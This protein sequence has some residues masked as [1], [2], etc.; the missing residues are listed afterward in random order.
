MKKSQTNLKFFIF[1]YFGWYN[2]GDDSIGLVILQELAK[3]YPDSKLSA[4]IN[5]SY[6]ISKN[7]LRNVEII[8][9]SLISILK[10]IKNSDEF[11]IAGGTHFQDEDQFFFRRLKI[12][13]FFLLITIYSRIIGKYPILLGHG[14]G[15]I[16]K[17]STRMMLKFIFSN[18]KSINV[19]DHSSLE[20][21]E[22]I[23]YSNKCSKTFDL[24]VCLLDYYHV[25]FNDEFEIIGISLLPVYEIYYGD[26][27]KDMVLVNEISKA[28]TG[29]L[30]ENKKLVI[31]LFAFRSGILHSDENILNELLSSLANFQNRISFV[32]YEG[33]ISSFF[34]EISS[35]DYFIG[36]RYHSILFSYILQKPI[37]A[38]NYME[39]CANLTEEILLPPSVIL[40]LDEVNAQIIRKKIDLI[41]SD[42]KNYIAKYPIN[43]ALKNGKSSF[44][45]LKN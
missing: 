19:R 11:I 5:D 25:S 21:V 31:K 13:F 32:K 18:V 20:V 44:N 29:L 42:H 16:S 37:I 33:E 30:K 10:A 7:D 4:T 35:C 12:N 38:I 28:L 34:S 40:K 2:V 45:I 17:F 14:I 8:D 39:K 3:K 22:D 23:G 43:N 26:I 41:I 1:G 36:M 27:N 24:A 6:F 9:F 15:P